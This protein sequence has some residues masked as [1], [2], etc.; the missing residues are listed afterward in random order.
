ML[1]NGHRRIIAQNAIF[2]AQTELESMNDQ[3]IPEMVDAISKS[4]IDFAYNK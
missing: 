3:Y 4:R 1:R 2:W